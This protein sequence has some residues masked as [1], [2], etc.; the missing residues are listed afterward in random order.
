[1]SDVL[2]VLETWCRE[3]QEPLR[4]R[5]LMIEVSVIASHAKSSRYVDVESHKALGRFTVWASGEAEIQIQPFDTSIEGSI[6][7]VTVRTHDDIVRELLGVVKSV[8]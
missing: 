7:T 6:R 1:M 3:N 4:A 5:G 8:E 2:N